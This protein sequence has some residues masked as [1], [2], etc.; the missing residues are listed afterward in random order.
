MHAPIAAHFAARESLAQGL[1]QDARR[2]LRV[3][4]FSCVIEIVSPSAHSMQSYLTQILQ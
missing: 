4:F 3:L 2:A 1:R